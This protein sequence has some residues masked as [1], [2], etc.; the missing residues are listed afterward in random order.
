MA[1]RALYPCLIIVDVQ[2]DYVLPSGALPCPDALAIIPHIH[3]AAHSSFFSAGIYL[4]A[5][6]KSPAC[7]SIQTEPGSCRWPPHCISGSFGAQIHA[8]LC[9]DELP[10]AVIITK[11]S[12]MSA[13][14]S[15][16]KGETTSLLMQL[17]QRP[18]SHA[19]VCG[20]A[21]EC[22]D[23]SVSRRTCHTQCVTLGR[24]C[25][26]ETAVDCIAMQLPVCV[27]LDGSRHYR[28]FC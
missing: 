21:L 28:W 10:G 24:Y 15:R 18:P 1:D 16:V 26:M 8:G 2:N 3:F 12:S 20:L 4:S 5:D 19:V 13:F 7:G 11:R 6:D 9:L 25:V 27:V 22:A 23:C 17:Q 14:G